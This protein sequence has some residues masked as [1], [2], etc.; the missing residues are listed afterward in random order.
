[1]LLAPVTFPPP[2]PSAP[3]PSSRPGETRHA[4]GLEAHLERLRVLWSSAVH[5]SASRVGLAAL[6]AAALL[7]AHVA[8]VGTT[9]ARMLAATVLALALGVELALR[10]RRRRAMR[11]A[12]G[13]IASVLRHADPALAARALR[14]LALTERTRLDP[15][16]GSTELAALHLSRTITAVPEGRVAAV[17]AARGRALRLTATVIAIATAI[18]LA[19]FPLRALEG[20]DVLVASGR[21]AP[22]P[23]DYVDDV[24]VS[25]HPPDYL[26]Q[27]DRHHTRA[28]AA[29]VPYG[30]LVTVHGRLLHAGRRVV[31]TDGASEVPFVDDGNGGVTSVWPIKDSV[32]L[33]IAARLG[34]VWIEQGEPVELVSVPDLAPVVT[35]AKAPRT[36][37]LL[38]ETDI[39]VTYEA[40]DDH[41]LRE[42]DLVLRAGAREERRVL[43]KLDGDSSHDAGGATIRASDRFVRASYLPVEITV[44]ARDNDPI[45]GPKWGRSAPITLVPPALGEPEAMRYA[46]LVAARDAMIDLLA[47][48][49]SAKTPSSPKERREF[50]ADESERLDAAIGAV[51]RALAGSYGGLTVARRFASFADGQLRKMR[52]TMKAEIAAPGEV[53]HKL[54]I[55]ATEAAALGLDRAVRT[56]G[57]RD[58]QK[59]A[60]RLSQVA[61]DAADGYL[62]ARQEADPRPGRQRAAAAVMVIA[63]SGRALARLGSLGADLG[64]IV[65]NDLA[66]LRRADDASDL[67][68]AELVMRDLA[69]RLARPNA[70]FSGGG[71]GGAESGGSGE[72]EPGDEAPSDAEDAFD[73]EQRAIEELARDHAGN[74]E[75]VQQAL[76]RAGSGAEMEAFLE[77]AKKHA[78]AVRE[79]IERLRADDE[80]AARAAREQAR[81]MAE[82]LERG[83]A[84]E[85]VEAGRLAE[86]SL[87]EAQR[88]AADDDPIQKLGQRDAARGAKDAQGKL[89]PEVRWAEDALSKMRKAMRDRASLGEAGERE[90]R[91]AERAKGVEQ[92]GR[93]S[94]PEPTTETVR[95]AEA[96]MREASRAL[97]KGDAERALAR[98]RE[99]QRLL[100]SAQERR[101]DEEQDE[102]DKGGKGAKREG[103][104]E[105]GGKAP[106]PKADDHKGP[107]E[108]RRR[109]MEG[110]ARGQSAGL[111]PA[112][113]RYAERLLR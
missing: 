14:A 101:G 10:V 75:D 47:H 33:R 73:A 6:F 31:I 102:G 32:R 85:A 59:T 52:D 2:R 98:Q 43:S 94:L 15:S 21:R 39:P 23:L 55:E 45:T 17:A 66:R 11:E 99:A 63:P 37:R 87:E 89:S 13:A 60:K 100:E 80:G 82:A 61:S 12:A 67:V 20:L 42:V 36:V 46:A 38:E 1:M 53:S 107:D 7:V 81:Q 48:R 110:L 96:E 34:E 77:E 71:G 35:V 25:V 113:Q 106:I 109:V 90:Q 69:A 65:E 108:F 103:G 74:L 58:A 83:D 16:A 104:E 93:G 76:H 97:E 78:E 3:P 28:E 18:V 68:H 26:H 111:K 5:A 62:A 9:P 22:M 19:I 24:V 72:P 92:R 105:V 95:R 86:K 84:K 30:S 51:R 29:D 70:S 88:G 64:S 79:A 49:I 112:V 91:L 41:G 27:K 4:P 44:E 50:A 56:L 8:R 40:T 57:T 54:G